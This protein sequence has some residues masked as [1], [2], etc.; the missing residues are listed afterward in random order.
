[1]T[2]FVSDINTIVGP[3][4]LITSIYYLASSHWRTHAPGAGWQGAGSLGAVGRWMVKGNREGGRGEG[5]TT[6][7]GFDDILVRKRSVEI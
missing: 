1:M 5:G 3:F 2:H 6:P 7:Q 4:Y